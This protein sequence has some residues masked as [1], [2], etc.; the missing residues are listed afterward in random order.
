VTAAPDDD[1]VVGSAA[2]GR[3]G[4]VRSIFAG[5]WVRE[6]DIVCVCVCV[7]VCVYGDVGLVFSFLL[8][9]KLRCFE[10]RL[11]LQLMSQLRG[12]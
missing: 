9:E 11:C 5:G 12:L 1:D 10:E 2:L 4:E 3:S 7:C 6:D 8:G